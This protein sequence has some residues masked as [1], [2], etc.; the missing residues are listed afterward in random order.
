[1][2]K[3]EKRSVEVKY[4]LGLIGCIL[5]VGVLQGG[6]DG[7]RDGKRNSVKH[8]DVEGLLMGPF[9]PVSVRSPT[10]IE[11]FLVEGGVRRNV[12]LELRG[13]KKSPDDE[14]N[15]EVMKWLKN[16][17][18]DV[19]EDGLYVLQNTIIEP[20]ENVIRGV[21]LTPLQDSVMH[22][23]DTGEEIRKVF[24]YRVLQSHGL[25]LAKVLLDE[26]DTDFGWDKDFA[27]FQKTGRQKSRG[28]WSRDL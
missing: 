28:Y 21:V 12:I 6:C 14:F 7:M 5:L 13:V 15:A 24:L 22:D 16:R 27:Y 10:E 26:T 18:H 11:A 9:T 23:L 19:R 17:M 3:W 2:A 20:S 4:S 1:M 8:S 25:T